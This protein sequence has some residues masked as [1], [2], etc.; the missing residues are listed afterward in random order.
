MLLIPGLQM[1]ASDGALCGP[2]QPV[3]YSEFKDSQ[4]YRV[5]TCL[6]NKAKTKTKTN[7]QTKNK[8]NQSI[9]KFNFLPVMSF[10]YTDFYFGG[11]KNK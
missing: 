2:E 6:K 7:K 11:K 8:E 9:V 10:L 1:A 3:Q 5:R 4:G